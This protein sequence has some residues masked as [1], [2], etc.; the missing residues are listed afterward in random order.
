M[1]QGQ[2]LLLTK[3]GH[4]ETGAGTRFC[5]HEKMFPPKNNYDAMQEIKRID[6]TRRQ[7]ELLEQRNKVI[8]SQGAPPRHQIPPGSPL[9]FPPPPRQQQQQPSQQPPQ[10]QRPP[11]PG[12]QLP[13]YH[14]QH[15]PPPGLQR[16]P[17]PPVDRNDQNFSI[18]SLEGPGG[19]SYFPIGGAGGEGQYP[20]ASSPPQ[21]PKDQRP[22]LEHPVTNKYVCGVKG[23]YRSGRV[24]GGE[25]A[26]P[27]EWCWQARN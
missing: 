20:L 25:D 27:G 7:Q 22:T 21:P 5:N 14:G 3:V 18:N 26:T 9:S 10:L 1:R 12:G 17:Q 8:Y 24:V 6:H 15:P 23:T 13:P 4:R 11:R 16:P 19:A 2:D